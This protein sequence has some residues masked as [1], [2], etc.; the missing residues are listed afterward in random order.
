M[1]QHVMGGARRPDADVVGSILY[2]MR[3][4]HYRTTA[5]REP[6]FEWEASLGWAY[7]TR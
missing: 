2:D 7:Q 4:L 6:G 5:C 1:Q 3:C